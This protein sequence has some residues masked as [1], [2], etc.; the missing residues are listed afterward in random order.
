MTFTL[1]KIST[2]RLD[3][4]LHTTF[5]KGKPCLEAAFSQMNCSSSGTPSPPTLI[6]RLARALIPK[7]ALLSVLTLHKQTYPI[8][9][10]TY[11]KDPPQKNT[12]SN[13]RIH[14]APRLPQFLGHISLMVDPPPASP[15][16]PAPQ[17]AN[18]KF[19]PS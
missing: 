5:L 11:Q 16:L 10:R 17:W 18:F 15:L 4:T 3:G 7:I 2:S 13:P 12:P 9:I 19:L 1:S 8:K 14:S 6:S